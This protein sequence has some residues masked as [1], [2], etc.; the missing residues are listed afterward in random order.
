LKKKSG[1]IEPRVKVTDFNVEFGLH[2]GSPG[3]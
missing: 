1:K 2:Y 3:L